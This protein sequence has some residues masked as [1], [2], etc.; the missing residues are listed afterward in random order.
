MP[1]GAV[2]GAIGFE[3]TTPSSRTKCATRLR[4]APLTRWV[5]PYS[6][7]TLIPQAQPTASAVRPRAMSRRPCF[8]PRGDRR[9]A[10]CPPSRPSPGRRTR[11]ATDRQKN[12]P[13]TG[14][15]FPAPCSMVPP[16]GA[17]APSRAGG[18]SPSGK[19]ADFDSAIR[20]FESSRPSQPFRPNG[21]F[22]HLGEFPRVCR[23]LAGSPDR[24]ETVRGQFWRV[25]AGI[26]R[27][28]SGRE[29]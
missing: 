9:P 28:V 3:P 24:A 25:T 26:L 2:V 7:R 23:D 21:H 4:Y 18:A 5:P 29:K 12:R 15:P 14:F 11:H 1:Q 17:A 16:A 8:A 10:A 6:D 22:S 19:A 27:R 20:R 13:K